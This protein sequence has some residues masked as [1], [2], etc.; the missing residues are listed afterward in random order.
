[1]RAGAFAG[2]LPTGWAAPGLAVAHCAAALAG[3]LTSCAAGAAAT[4]ATRSVRPAAALAALPAVV[5]VAAGASLPDAALA[6][7]VGKLSHRFAA[8]LATTTLISRL[9]THVSW[10]HQALLIESDQIQATGLRKRLH[11]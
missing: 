7:L 10:L 11:H 5:A 4:A 8:C 1:M 3:G 2:A 9:S 6:T